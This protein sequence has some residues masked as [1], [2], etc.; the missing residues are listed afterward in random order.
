MNPKPNRSQPHPK[1]GARAPFG[2]RAALAAIGNWQLGQV[3]PANPIAVEYL[4]GLFACAAPE[5]ASA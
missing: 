2:L 1:Q 4:G 5:R 3:S